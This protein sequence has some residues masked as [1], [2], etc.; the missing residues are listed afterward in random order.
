[1]AF[2]SSALAQ[3]AVLRPRLAIVAPPGRE[4]WIRVRIDVRVDVFFGREVGW[5]ASNVARA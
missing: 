4:V 3:E 5:I 2:S 1:M